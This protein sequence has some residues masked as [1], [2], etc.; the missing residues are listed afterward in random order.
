MNDSRVLIHSKDGM[1]LHKAIDEDVCQFWLEFDVS[2]PKYDLRQILGVKMYDLMV[3]V[4]KDII[5]NIVYIQP[6]TT[7]IDNF[8]ACILFS[9]FGAELGIAQ[10]YMCNKIDIVWD[11]PRDLK[12]YIEQFDKPSSL[13]MGNAESV[14]NSRGVIHIYFSDEHNAHVVYEFSMNLDED[15]PHY[16]KKLPG[17]LMSKIFTRI[18]TFVEHM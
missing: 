16:M 11:S 13:D 15:I 5:E 17:L 4:N 14:I 12:Y 18:K 2:N 7:E 8:T 6:P 9:R 3:S 10:K 1:T